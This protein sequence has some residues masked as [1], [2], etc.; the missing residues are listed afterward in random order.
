MLNS[1][2]YVLFFDVAVMVVFGLILQSFVTVQMCINVA[3]SC[4][5]P[6]IILPRH[7][8][9]VVLGLLHCKANNSELIL[10]SCG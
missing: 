9:V 3:P 10:S 2:S 5:D 4:G 8:R 6:C 1:Y 7:Y